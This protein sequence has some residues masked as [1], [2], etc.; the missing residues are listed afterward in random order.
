MR[1]QISETTPSPSVKTKKGPLLDGHAQR[2][3]GGARSDHQLVVSSPPTV[4][5]ESVDNVSGDGRPNGTCGAG[6][7]SPVAALIKPQA[8]ISSYIERPGMD[9][10]SFLCG[11]RFGARRV[12]L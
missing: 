1:S 10:S 5:A 12:T 8:L 9:A 3:L 2:C 11:S 7:S 4:P 6:G